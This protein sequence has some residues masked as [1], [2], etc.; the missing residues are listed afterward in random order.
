MR[1]GW[2]RDHAML[3]GLV[4][5]VISPIGK[6]TSIHASW[7]SERCSVW[8]RIRNVRA[9]IGACL[10]APLNRPSRVEELPHARVCV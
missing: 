2:E 4:G 5:L 8:G 10:V 7:A 1:A 3:I 6:Q 9:R